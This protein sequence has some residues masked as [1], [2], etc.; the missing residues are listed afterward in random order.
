MGLVETLGVSKYS[1]TP[2]LAICASFRFRHE[3]DSSG[4]LITTA[5][6]NPISVP[7]RQ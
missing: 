1:R 3:R 4:G 6:T 5:L 2:V 7:S